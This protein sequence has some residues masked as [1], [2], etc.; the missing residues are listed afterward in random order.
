MSVRAVRLDF[1]WF[2]IKKVGGVVPMG[3]DVYFPA[4]D[5]SAP[6]RPDTV[7]HGHSDTVAFQVVNVYMRVLL[8][9]C[10][11]IGC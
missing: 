3:T 4:E 5:P 9:R 7:T 11:V 6:V 10:M 8:W 2:V 1:V